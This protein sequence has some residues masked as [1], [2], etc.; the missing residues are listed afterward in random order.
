MKKNTLFLVIISLL[1]SL[2]VGCGEKPASIDLI[3]YNQEQGKAVQL[4]NA[5]NWLN[6]NVV[7][8]GAVLNARFDTFI[9]PNCSQGDGFGTVDVMIPVV[10]DKGQVTSQRVYASLECPTMGNNG[11]IEK[12]S[13]K[14][15][16]VKTFRKDFCNTN[17]PKQFPKVTG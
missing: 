7:P 8:D 14:R 9:G 13:I 17:L 15:G 5:R 16:D 4:S 12:E 1:L 2:L 3:T 10:D 6:Q 11:C